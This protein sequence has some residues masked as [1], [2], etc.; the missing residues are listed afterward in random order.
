MKNYTKIIDENTNI[1]YLYDTKNNKVVIYSR[2]LDV[3]NASVELFMQLH[4]E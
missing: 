3:F 2:Y 1:Y 4:G